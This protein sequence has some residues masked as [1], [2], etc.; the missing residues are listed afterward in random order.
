MGTFL[1]SFCYGLVVAVLSMGSVHAENDKEQQLYKMRKKMVEGNLY[2]FKNLFDSYK[3]DNAVYPPTELGF[4]ALVKNPMSGPAAAK[5]QGPYV[6]E[7]PLD[8]WN[9]PY[10]YQLES[11]DKIEIF[12]FGRDGKPGGE[13]IDKDIKLS[14][15]K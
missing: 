10:Q 9:H 15:F 14:D 2:V 13:G 4:S 5:W 11:N 6:K 12:S 1:K 3:K 8:V 7:I